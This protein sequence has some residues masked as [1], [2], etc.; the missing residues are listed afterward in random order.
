MK[1]VIRLLLLTLLAATPLWAGITGK[2]TGTVSDENGE[3]LAGVNVVIE[4]Q[5]RGGATDL[6]GY[7]QILNLPPGV[8]TLAAS[9]VGYATARVENVAVSVDLT[10]HQDLQLQVAALEG[11]TVTIVAKR[12][13]VQM[14][15]T[16]SASYVDAR[17]LKALPVT[18][19]SE[20]VDRQAG[21]VDGHFRGGRGGEVLYMVDGIPVTDVYDNSRGAEV[22]VSMVQELQVISGTFNA[23]YG[24]AMSGVVNTVTRDGNDHLEGSFNLYAG[25]YVSNHT[26]K[27]WN[28]DELEVFNI[29][30]AEFNLSGPIPYLPKLTF[31]MTGRYSKNDGWLEGLDLFDPQQYS[32][33]G[34]NNGRPFRIFTDEFQGVNGWVTQEG[35]TMVFPI[36]TYLDSLYWAQD[37]QN[38]SADSVDTWMTWANE[39]SRERYMMAEGDN[40]DGAEY[41]HMNTEERRAGQL[42]LTYAFSPTS[43][44]RVNY[45]VNDRDYQE[46]DSAWRFT[47]DGRLKR[48]SLSQT[49]SLKWDLVPSASTFLDVSLSHSLSRYH[50]WLYSDILDSR[51]I[52]SSEWPDSQDY[53]YDFGGA[54]LWQSDYTP[55]AV[56]VGSANVGGTDN[57]NFQR[58]TDSWVGR[59]NISHQLG[60]YHEVKAGFETKFHRIFFWDRNVAFDGDEIVQPQGGNYDRYTRYPYEG[61]LYLQDKMEFDQI[62]LNIGLRLDY[63][64][65]NWR[66]PVDLT[67]LRYLDEPQT[68]WED[69]SMK[70]ALSPRLAVAYPISDTG[71]I[72]FSYGHFFQRPSFEVLYTNPDFELDGTNTIMGNPDL[73]VER[74]VQYEIG[75]QQQ[76]GEQ[77]GLDVSLYSRDIRDLVST[78]LI[79]ETTTVDYYYMYTN[80]DFGSVKGV[81]IALD[82][83][84][85][86]SVNL[87]MDYTWQQAEAN[88]SDPAAARNEAADGG[89]VN[90]Y[91][92][93]MDWD[94]RHTLN[95]TGSYTYGDLWGLSTIF[96]YGSGTPYTPDPRADEPVV[97]LLSN[98]GNK[99]AYM[100]VDLSGYY[101]VPLPLPQ[102]H[103]MQL[104]FQVLNLLDRSNENGVYSKTGRAGYDLDWESSAPELWVEPTHWS[105]PRQVT[106]GVRYSF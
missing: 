57:A 29:G 94:R 100:N 8:Y 17:E 88:A 84:V 73:N 69:V 38:W 21:V 24:Q 22:Q 46:Y 82:H 77:T 92:V 19:L 95:L 2:I 106:A 80:R 47:P 81:V 1:Q 60:R 99:P 70:W 36:D 3:P 75:L 15:Q 96:T 48:Y 11:E 10:T 67:E 9:S 59:G 85:G 32:I 25:D 27:F 74:T 87:G 98:S 68:E 39:Y 26:D 23:E 16:F 49:T 33:L 86:N 50:H 51:Y 103:S 7:Y 91:L 6:D 64:D 76:L 12:E 5:P 90:K 65:A 56:F 72:H 63:F 58:R 83:R 45:M 31:N 66:L 79:I 89:E 35:D 43:K 34:E 102:G 54:N 55:D 53:Y 97:G 20:V 13:I 61:A 41:V 78:D 42:K 101:N 28:V 62:T 44:L 30:N 40:G 104:H 4:G 18:E 14:D 105:R 37:V 71:M 52:N 93:P